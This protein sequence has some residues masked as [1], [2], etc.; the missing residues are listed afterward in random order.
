VPSSADLPIG[1]RAL[2]ARID[3]MTRSEREL[4][5]LVDEGRFEEL[6]ATVSPEEIARSWLGYHRASTRSDDPDEDPGWWAVELFLRR[7]VT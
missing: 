7:A 1:R 3:G 4:L 2:S 6:H 5:R